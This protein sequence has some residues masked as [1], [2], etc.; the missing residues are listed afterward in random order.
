LLLFP[1]ELVK[2]VE[3][4]GVTIWK[5]ISS[6]LMYMARTGCLK[7]ENMPTLK[8]VLFAGEVLPTKYLI[9]W[10]QCY[11]AKE[12]YNG[13]GPTEATGMSTYYR[14]PA[15]PQDP[16]D[17]IPIGRACENTEVLLLDEKGTPSP[18]GE[19]GELCIRGSG[20]SPGY[21]NDS[22][23]TS[24][25]FVSVPLSVCRSSTVYRTG[26]LAR[27]REDGVL[28]FLGRKDTQVKWMGHR[29]ELGEIESALL[30]L[31]EVRGA[32]VLF[33]DGGQIA[34]QGIVAFVEVEGCRDTGEILR[35]LR[36]Q[37]PDYMLPRRI[38]AMASL[39]RTDRGKIDRVKLKHHLD[40]Q[41]SAQHAGATSRGPS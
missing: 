33:L 10:M 41:D 1:S 18:K 30:S 31:A 9:E 19:I 25:V 15:A 26:D 3:R 17:S 16:R 22:R 34:D 12:F 14:I 37:I 11:P 2:F 35:E 8:K 7:P 40:A 38:L 24:Q 27:E 29:I 36:S 39:P 23:K 4:Q 21:W 32:A 20:V 6:L 5:G 28:E 13:Y